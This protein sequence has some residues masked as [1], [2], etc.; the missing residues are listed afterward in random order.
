M[1]DVI[2]TSIR[3]YLLCLTIK[4]ITAMSET[5]E[6]GTFPFEE[7][8]YCEIIQVEDSH[9][10]FRKRITNQVILDLVEEPLEDEGY[11][12]LSMELADVK[13]DGKP[14][15]EMNLYFP[16]KDKTF[17]CF[18][19]MLRKYGVERVGIYQPFSGQ[20]GIFRDDFAL[21]VSSLVGRRVQFVINYFLHDCACHDKLFACRNSRCFEVKKRWFKEELMLKAFSDRMVSREVDRKWTNA[22]E[23][24]CSNVCLSEKINKYKAMSLDL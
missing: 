18:M 7:R 17:P 24:F 1:N 22:K 12:F 15:R 14:Q 13:F 4:K 21:R 23:A 16:Y 6:G 10:K 19:L 5:I 11:V 3:I 8:W 9:L 2:L 20:L